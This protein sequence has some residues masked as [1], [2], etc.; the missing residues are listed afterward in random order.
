MGVD[1]IY[2]H[3]RFRSFVL[4]QYK[5]LLKDGAGPWIYRP[6]N[7]RNFGNEIAKMREFEQRHTGGIASESPE[8]Y[9][10]HPHGF[11]FKF[12]PAEVYDP[13]STDLISGMY[14][15]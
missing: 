3:S 10:L 12:A 1:L 8:D 15:P 9:R 5:R 14:M 7:D 2:Y 13:L 4:V 6:D 11:Y